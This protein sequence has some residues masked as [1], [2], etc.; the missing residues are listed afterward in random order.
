MKRPIETAVLA[1]AS[2][3]ATVAPPAA[4]QGD[5]ASFRGDP[6]LSGRAATE[7][8]VLNMIALA[9]DRLA[10][11]PDGGPVGLLATRGTI[12]AGFYQEALAARGLDC[13][14]APEALNQAHLLPAIAAVKAG[15]MDQA[16]AGALAA[17]REMRALGAG[18]LL[19]ACS[20][21]SVCWPESAR[22]G[23]LDACDVLAAA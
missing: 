14:V 6:Q 1:L 21:L 8:P 18:T 7:L 2:L 22:A 5:W 4:A 13:L 19:L 15:S 17:A 3:L 10:E 9:A 23:T 20:E 16:A 12:A 11:G